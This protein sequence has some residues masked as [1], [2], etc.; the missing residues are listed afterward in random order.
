MKPHQERILE[1]LNQ[2]NER[3]VKLTAFLFKK[4]EPTSNADEI[5]THEDIRGMEKQLEA[6]IEYS[7]I[8]RQRANRFLP[9]PTGDVVG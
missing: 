3:I 7:K 5:I 2:L 1:E 8:L 9:Y 4:N 6:M